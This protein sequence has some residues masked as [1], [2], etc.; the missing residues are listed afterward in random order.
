M[1]GSNLGMGDTVVKK[2]N[3]SALRTLLEEEAGGINKWTTKT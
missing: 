1:P 2:I 3:V